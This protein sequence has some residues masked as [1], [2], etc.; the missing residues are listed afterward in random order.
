MHEHSLGINDN[1]YTHNRRPLCLKYIESYTDINEAIRREKQIKKWSQVKKKALIDKQYDKLST[2]SHVN[3]STPQSG[4]GR[5]RSGPF[6]A[7]SD[8]LL[9]LC[10]SFARSDMLLS[11][12]SK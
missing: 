6:G 11:C 5:P 10:T 7:R 2:L 12:C 9:Y 4:A 1:S 8:M 3:F